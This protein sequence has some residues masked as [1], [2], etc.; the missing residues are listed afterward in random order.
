MVSKQKSKN[1][2]FETAKFPS[3]QAGKNIT[4]MM[5]MITIIHIY[6]A[7]LPLN[8]HRP[9]TALWHMGV[10]LISISWF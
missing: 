4:M 1:P 6:T 2:T 10:A 8:Q 7:S 3:P 5:I 9:L